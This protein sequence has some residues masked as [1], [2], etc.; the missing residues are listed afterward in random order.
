M[1]KAYWYKNRKVFVKDTKGKVRNVV[2]SPNLK[3][4]LLQENLIETIE[5]EIKKLQKK[6]KKFDERYKSDGDV[7]LDVFA[8]LIALFFGGIIL[9]FMQIS[10][11]G[12]S[13]L[14][15]LPY[16]LTFGGI[17]VLYVALTIKRK[18]AYIK[19]C[20][21]VSGREC[22]INFLEKQMEEEKIKL[23]EEK[24]L[25]ACFVENKIRITKINTRISMKKVYE[26]YNFY[27]NCGFLASAFYDHYQKNNCLP[28]HLTEY[29]TDS[30]IKEIEEYIQKEGPRLSKR[31]H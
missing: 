20:N 5:N 12:L 23:D 6:N 31:L 27:Y 28:E 15:S 21:K 22:Q 16:L 2:Y 24:K 4:I 9:T 1:N 29:Y 18:K 17:S 30:Q 10:K 25:T 7:L 13:G 19:R 3:Q 26:N 8:P 14:F 11:F